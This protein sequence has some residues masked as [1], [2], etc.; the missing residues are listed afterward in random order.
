MSDL[1]REKIEILQG[2]LSHK[3]ESII[4]QAISGYFGH[5]DWLI[6][7]VKDMGYWEVRPDKPYEKTLVFNGV[8]LLWLHDPEPVETGDPCLIRFE[9][10]YKILY[11][12]EVS[13][14]D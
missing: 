13:S 6:D 7:D 8:P 4:H 12:K 2:Q 10:K 3:E 14:D 5:S 9:Q 11:N 1:M